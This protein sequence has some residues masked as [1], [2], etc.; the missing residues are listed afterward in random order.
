MLSIDNNF[1]P[2]LKTDI[3]Q[4]VTFVGFS[5]YIWLFLSSAPLLWLPAKRQVYFLL[6]YYK[7]LH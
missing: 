5:N 1:E 4:T 7:R 2:C 6:E 3:L